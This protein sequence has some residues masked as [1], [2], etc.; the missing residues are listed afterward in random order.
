[1]IRL[2][3][4]LE[5]IESLDGLRF[6]R[7]KILV[8]I[9]LEQNTRSVGELGLDVGNIYT[10]IQDDFIP[11]DEYL[12]H[13]GIVRGLPSGLRSRFDLGW[14]LDLE[15]G[16]E[17]YL[18]HF[19]VDSSNLLKVGGK[20]YYFFDYVR[21]FMTYAVPMAYCKSN[22]EMLGKW[23]FVKLYE[24]KIEVGA[25][26]KVFLHENR[27]TVCHTFKGSNVNEGDEVFINPDGIY[28]IIVEGEKYWAVDESDLLGVL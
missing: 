27:G 26:S 17:I 1:M 14:G 20:T 25:F 18:H 12:P 10:K 11:S 16:D 13:K 7:N 8:E 9:D 22:M 28:S 2:G 5:N 23:T 19:V 24:E 4:G 21:E 6:T 3:T 15:L